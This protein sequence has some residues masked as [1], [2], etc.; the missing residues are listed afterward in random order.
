[1]PVDNHPVYAN[2]IPKKG[3]AFYFSVDSTGLNGPSDTIRVTPSF[4]WQ[5]DLN[6][7]NRQRT[8]IYYHLDNEYFI[9]VGSSRDTS[10]I[11]HRGYNIG[12]YS[13]LTLPSALRTII[14]TQTA[15]WDSDYYISSRRIAVK[16]GLTP[17]DT[18]NQLTGGYI[19]IQFQLE[20][21]KNGVLMFQYT[22][23]QYAIEG[24]PKLQSYQLGDV[25]VF[26]NSKSALDDYDVNSDR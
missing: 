24:G 4:Y 23:T 14:D 26:D 5:Q 6:G 17:E 11:N 19:I 1:M 16:K 7:T 18:A 3:Y 10:A 15:T 9:K 8:D 2:A 20:A 12:G 22:P 13:S 21:Y 25:I